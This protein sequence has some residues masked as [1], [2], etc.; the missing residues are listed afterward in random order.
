LVVYA[1]RPLGRIWKANSITG[2]VLNTLQFFSENGNK[3][4]YKELSRFSKQ[5][6]SHS[7][8]LLKDFAAKCIVSYNSNNLTVF[9]CHSNE[10]LREENFQSESDFLL[11]LAQNSI[12]RYFY[13]LLQDKGKIIIKSCSLK[14][15]EEA[16]SE[17]FELQDGDEAIRTLLKHEVLWSRKNIEKIFDNKEQ[18]QNQSLLKDPKFINIVEKVF[19]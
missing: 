16:F 3:L 17:C 4:K 5:I 8:G 13:V 7:V 12:S 19:I 10:I 11:L 15:P 6:L 18:I 9:D 1:A 14:T 2:R